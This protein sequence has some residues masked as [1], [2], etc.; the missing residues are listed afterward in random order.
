MIIPDNLS[1]P[2]II[3]FF[4]DKHE[5]A[6]KGGVSRTAQIEES[7][8]HFP[9]QRHTDEVYILRDVEERITA[10]AVIT[11]RR[12][13]LLGIR[14]ADCVPILLYDS[15][16]EAIAAVH[17]G[18]RGTAKGILKKTIELMRSAYGTHPR[19][20]YLACGPSIRWCCYTVGEDVLRAVQVQTGEGEFF[21]RKNGGLCLDL[22][23]ANKLQALSCGIVERNIW[24]SGDCTYCFPERF[25]SYRFSGSGGR[26]GGFI[27]LK[28]ESVTES[29]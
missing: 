8:I 15:S 16:H 22:V 17:A 21:L 13:V 27:G 10:D 24:I 28:R 4:T 3:A 11:E 7:Q 18:W 14:V 1:S 2:G 25:H 23:T 26:Q 19:N 20:M 29:L 12:G 6:E 5:G 9:V